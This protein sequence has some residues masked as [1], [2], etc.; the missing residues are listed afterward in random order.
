MTLSDTPR[1]KDVVKAEIKKIVLYKHGVGYFERTAEVNG[2]A[3][4]SLSFKMDQMK[5]LLTSF[6]AVDLHGGR[7]TS[8]G[9]DSKDPIEKQLE[10]ILT[11]NKIY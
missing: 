2:D 8:I 4:I 10:N 1:L 7:I 3:V 6:F 11:R 9:Y 5:D